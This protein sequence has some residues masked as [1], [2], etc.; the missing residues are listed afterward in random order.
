MEDVSR[1]DYSE[2]QKAEIAGFIT[3]TPVDPERIRRSQAE[4]NR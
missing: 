1:T 2:S 4:A 3:R